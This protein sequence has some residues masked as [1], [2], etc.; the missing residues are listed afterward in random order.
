MKPTLNLLQLSACPIFNQLQLEEALLRADKRNW[1]LIN[2]GSTP[3]IVMGISGK[4]E[5]LI[6]KDMLLQQPVTVI[7]RFSGGGT[8]FVDEHTCFVTLI[9]NSEE[10]QLTCCPQKV[11]SWT[12]QLYQ[13]VFPNM[14]FRLVENDYVLNDRKF[15]GNAQYLCKQRWL[16]HS[17]LLW[18]FKS[19][20]MNYLLFPPKTPQY[21]ERRNHNDFLCRLRDYHPRMETLQDQIISALKQHFTVE[22]MALE[23]AQEVLDRPHRKATSFVEM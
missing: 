15:G 10:T 9:C 22:D 11:L 21:R 23:D 6:N 19:A 1:C 4:P 3:A 14:G 7:R 16:H 12:E 13:P 5:L 2:S 20:S 18:D 8:V 17:S